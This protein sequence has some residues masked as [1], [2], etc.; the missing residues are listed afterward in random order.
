M[1]VLTPQNVSETGLVPSTSAAAAGG[2]Q[3]ENTA[4]EIVAVTNGGGSPITITAHAQSV[5]KDVPG[6]GTMTK[7]NGGGAVAAGATKFFGP[8][9]TRAFNNTS[10]RVSLSYSST[11]SVTVAVLRMNELPN[12]L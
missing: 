11:T 12:T 9:P 8:F 7:A 10:G 5:S 1:A 3:F 2:D 4:R 6:Y